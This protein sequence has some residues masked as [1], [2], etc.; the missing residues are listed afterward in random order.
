MGPGAAI[1]IGTNSTR[2]LVAHKRGDCWK[3]LCRGLRITRLG[4][5]LS[6]TGRLSPEAMGR[7][8]SAV[9]EFMHRAQACGAEFLEIAAT[10]AARQAEN[11]E[12]LQQRLAAQGLGV[13]VLTG[14]EEAALSFRGVVTALSPR[15]PGPILVVDVG[16]GST[17]LIRGCDAR[18]E[19]WFSLPVGAVTLAERL[20]APNGVLSPELQQKMSREVERVLEMG[21]TAAWDEPARSSVVGVGGTATSLVA[22]CLELDSY[23]PEKVHGFSLTL[24]ELQSL[25]QKLAVLTDQQ[26]CQVP[27]LQPERADIIVPGAVIIERLLQRLGGRELMV[28]EGDLLLGLLEVAWTEQANG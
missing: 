20:P 9:V 12:Q 14:E 8:V 10:F 5:G 19:D 21:M 27:G 1:D 18:L 25:R 26:R 17:E 11:G 28:S 24:E 16:G 4:E 7:T 3:P 6:R 22:I 23:D 13:R 2:L 15:N